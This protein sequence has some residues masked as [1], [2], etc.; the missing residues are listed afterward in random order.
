MLDAGGLR[1]A[2][3][4]CNGA[5]HGFMHAER[6]GAPADAIDAEREIQNW[7]THGDKPDRDEP[8]RRGARIPLIQEGVNRGEHRHHRIQARGQVRPEP[9]E[10][11]E[12]AHTDKYDGCHAQ[13][14]YLDAKKGLTRSS[15]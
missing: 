8:K 12:P 10:Y 1:L 13:A 14:S 9:G 15:F 4:L 5:D 6:N 11:V 3:M 7:A 2:E